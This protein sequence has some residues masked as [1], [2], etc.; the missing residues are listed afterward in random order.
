MI[1]KTKLFIPI[2]LIQTVDLKTQLKG[3]F[4]RSNEMAEMFYF[5]NSGIILGSK[6]F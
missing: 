5:N 4:E 2:D 6:C 3:T 1:E